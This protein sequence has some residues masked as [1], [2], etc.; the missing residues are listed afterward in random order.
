MARDKG[1]SFTT[2]LA[3]A[4]VANIYRSAVESSVTF[5]EKVSGQIVTESIIDNDPF[6]QLEAQAD[7]SVLMGFKSKLPGNPGLMWAIHL[8]VFDEGTRRRVELVRASSG[9]AVRADRRF[10][11]VIAAFRK[12]DPALKEG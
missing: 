3:T 8:Y 6:S 12:A 4:Q 1:F 10:N 2:A 9:I 7:F 11:S 5:G